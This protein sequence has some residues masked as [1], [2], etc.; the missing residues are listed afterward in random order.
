MQND[1]TPAAMAIKMFAWKTGKLWHVD[2]EAAGNRPGIVRADVI[3]KLNDWNER[4]IIL[5][6]TSG[7]QH[8][9]RVLCKLP[10][11]PEDIEEIVKKLY[12]QMLARERQDLQRTEEVVSLV[13]SKS[14]ISRGLAAYFSDG[15][16]GVPTECGH[17]TWCETHKQTVLPKMPP[18]RPDPGLIAAVLKACSARDDPRFLARIAFG[19]TSPRVTAMKLGK[20]LVFGSMNVCDFMVGRYFPTSGYPVSGHCSSDVDEFDRNSS[21]YSQIYAIELDRLEE[22][23]SAS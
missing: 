10:S 22:Y 9:Y 7:V 14:C 8:V 13:T 18:A 6:K 21:G 11:T 20:H 4:D 1:T 12:A 15:S 19:I 23:D 3:R 5:L 17:C 16:Y 2:V